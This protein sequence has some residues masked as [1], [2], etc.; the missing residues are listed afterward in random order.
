MTYQFTQQEMDMLTALL[1]PFHESASKGHLGGFCVSV[2]FVAERVLNQLGFRNSKW[3][4]VQGHHYPGA[5]GHTW[6][7]SSKS[8]DLLILDL[9][10][11]Q[12]GEPSPLLVDSPDSRYVV[13][14]YID[15]PSPGAIQT[16][17]APVSKSL[18]AAGF[19]F[20]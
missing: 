15:C 10:A 8:E 1:A 13:E 17:L 11:C 5:I 18:G 3:V 16:W 20:H 7:V 9:T 14:R 2:S 12:F 6:L 4:V 19:E